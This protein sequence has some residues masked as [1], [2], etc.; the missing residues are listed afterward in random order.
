MVM[1]SG[2]EPVVV[3]IKSGDAALATVKLNRRLA[4]WLAP[5]VTVRVKLY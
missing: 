1:G 4:L 3:M 2:S 5:S